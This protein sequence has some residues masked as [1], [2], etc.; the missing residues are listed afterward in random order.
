VIGRPELKSDPRFAEREPRKT[1][2]AALNILI[3][4]VLAT[5]PAAEWEQRLNRAGVPAGRVLTVPQVLAEPQVSA[6]EMTITFE[7]VPG[8]DRT[9][10]VVRGGF[11]VDGQAPKPSRP[12]PR[13]GEHSEEILT[14]S[15][16]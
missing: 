11:L 1:N 8:V 3:D 10:T 2:R 14:E 5:A 6:R 4:E 7:D 15:G 13:L 9:V 12:P 16:G